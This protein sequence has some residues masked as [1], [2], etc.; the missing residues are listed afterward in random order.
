MDNITEI[1]VTGAGSAVGVGSILGYFIKRLIADID[2]IKVILNGELGTPGLVTQV[3]LNTAQDET[4]EEAFKELKKEFKV[5]ISSNPHKA[6]SEA[7]NKFRKEM[8]M[9]YKKK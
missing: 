5:H 9:N 4:R 1:I 2:A 6:I 8:E 3:E 7:L